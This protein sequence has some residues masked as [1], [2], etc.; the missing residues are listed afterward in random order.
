MFNSIHNVEELLIPFW[1]A[2]IRVSRGIVD[3]HIQGIAPL[4]LVFAVRKS[5]IITCKEF[6]TSLLFSA[7]L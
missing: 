2:Q 4:L 5:V 1:N 3:T 7:A 6:I